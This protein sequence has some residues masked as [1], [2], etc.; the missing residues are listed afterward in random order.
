MKRER[1]SKISAIN[2]EKENCLGSSIVENNRAKAT[3]ASLDDTQCVNQL[4]TSVIVNAPQ[5][6]V[7]TALSAKVTTKFQGE[8]YGFT[9]NYRAP[10]GSSLDK[11]HPTKEERKQLTE[12]EDK[13]QVFSDV[14]RNGL[15][16]EFDL[17]ALTSTEN[18]NQASAAEYEIDVTCN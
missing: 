2:G 17:V 5:Y 15:L 8:N 3:V 13:V 4:S 12:S 10:D 11:L 18:G 1:H 16:Y 9:W 6:P 14:I 7:G